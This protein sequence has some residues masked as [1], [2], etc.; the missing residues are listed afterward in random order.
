MPDARFKN[1]FFFKGEKMKIKMLLEGR[2]PTKKTDGAA[3]YDCYAAIPGGMMTIKPGTTT[4]V[5]LG[6][7]C[8]FE[9]GY[10]LEVRGRSGNAVKGLQVVTGTVDSDYRGM[11]GAICFNSTKEDIFISTGDRVAQIMIKQVIPSEIEIVK[12]LSETVR[13]S[14]GFGS[15]GK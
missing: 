13:G 1:A 7:K 11:V 15:T 8:E 12:E 5:P 3:C 10:Y 6:F 14:G 4:V 2:I 9:P